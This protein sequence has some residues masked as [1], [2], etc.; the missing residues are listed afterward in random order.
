MFWTIAA[1]LLLMWVLGMIT[2]YT[3]GGIIH[4]LL[5]FVLISVI[6]DLVWWRRREV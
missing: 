3:L 4:L 2:S 5:L 6:L 1:I